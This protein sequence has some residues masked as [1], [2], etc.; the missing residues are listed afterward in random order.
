MRADQVLALTRGAGLAAGH[1]DPE[2][3]DRENTISISPPGAKASA[4]PRRCARDF[5]WIESCEYAALFSSGSRPLG[6]NVKISETPVSGIRRIASLVGIC[7][8][9]VGNLPN[10]VPA[11]LARTRRPPLG[12]QETNRGRSPRGITPLV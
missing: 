11:P 12:L 1:S 9:L 6:G 2:Y 4:V 10:S 7:P 5:R 3:T 8:E